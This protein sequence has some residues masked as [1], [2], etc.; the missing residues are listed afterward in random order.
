MN[1]EWWGIDTTGLPD[2]EVIYVN[3]NSMVDKFGIAQNDDHAGWDRS[4]VIKI[5]EHQILVINYP[6]NDYVG[7]RG[8]QYNLY[9]KDTDGNLH[10]IL[11]GNTEPAWDT[12]T[13][14]AA[15]LT[16]EQNDKIAT[17][18][19]HLI[20]NIPNATQVNLHESAGVVLARR[21]T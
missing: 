2:Y 9:S 5:L 12:R 3:G 16:R 1:A 10:E 20:W 17:I 13:E 14:Q 19:E 4:G 18:A 21:L 11:N 8:F 6:E 15:Q 7:I